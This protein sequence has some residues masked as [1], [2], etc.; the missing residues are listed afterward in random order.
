M[1]ARQPERPRHGDSIRFHLRLVG[2]RG[3]GILACCDGIHA[4]TPPSPNSG[5]SLRIE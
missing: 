4:G 1:Q 3:A 2:F 5:F